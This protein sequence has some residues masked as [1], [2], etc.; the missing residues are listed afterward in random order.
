M[1]EIDG[2][3]FEGGGSI[4]RTT[5]SLSLATK[6]A[7]RIKNIRNNRNP[8]G[9]KPQLLES[10]KLA[11]KISNSK[12]TGLFPGS[13]TIEFF[14]G[15]IDKGK[16][17]ES[18]IGTAGSIN[19][20]LQTIFMPCFLSGYKFKFKLK[21]GTDV[22]FSPG[23]DYFKHVF[24]HRFIEY[25]DISYKVL[26]RGYYPKGQGEIEFSF[27]KNRK[28][29]NLEVKEL[30]LLSNIFIISHASNSLESINICEEQSKLA[31]L[32]LSDLN[33]PLEARNEYSNS[34]SEENGIFILGHF[35]GQE[36]V[37]IGNL[38]ERKNSVEELVKKSTS[39]FKEVVKSNYVDEYLTDMIIPWLA[40]FNGS[41]TFNSITEHMK[42]NIYVVNS[43]FDERIIVNKNKIIAQE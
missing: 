17:L 15:S 24:L 21:G 40:L 7:V 38:A 41:I 5:V 35:E 32:Y 43:F 16:S 6:K 18:D 29:I 26:K 10:L 25:G 14:P 13:K 27:K 3:K 22:P 23:S 19:L 2:S 39:T 30:S 42:A 9:L 34:K 28:K 1:I 8:P 12:A 11:L 33:K 37:G 36:R 31:E 4:V 20:L